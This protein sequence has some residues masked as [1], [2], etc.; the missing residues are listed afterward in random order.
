MCRAQARLESSARY[1]PT[2]NVSWI[3]ATIKLGGTLG[4]GQVIVLISFGRIGLSDQQML[5][6]AIWRMRDRMP[7]SKLIIATRWAP[8]NEFNKYVNDAKQ[9]I[10]TLQPLNEE[11]R[12]I[13]DAR[14]IADRLAKIPGQGLKI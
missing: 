12:A 3:W 10:I 11:R 9:D 4:R 13:L 14:R 8:V 1:N 7:E 5:H 2:T 6:N